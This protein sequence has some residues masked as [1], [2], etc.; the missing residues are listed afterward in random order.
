MRIVFFILLLTVFKGFGQDI[1]EVNKS[2]GL[3][4]NLEYER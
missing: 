4:E 2:L 1:F 3:S